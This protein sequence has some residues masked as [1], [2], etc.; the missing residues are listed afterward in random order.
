MLVTIFTIFIGS[1]PAAQCQLHALISSPLTV[2]STFVLVISPTS[3]TG[4]Q[5][6][7]P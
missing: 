3:I 1:V 5:S 6:I 2:L 4:V 7:R